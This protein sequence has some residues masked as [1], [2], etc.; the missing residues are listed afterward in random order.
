ML[1]SR[2]YKFF[3]VPSAHP[4]NFRTLFWFTHS[5]TLAAIYA[6]LALGEAFSSEYVVQDDARQHVFWMMRFIDP[7]LFP[8]D[9]IADYFQSVAPPGY[10]TL[11]QVAASLGIPPL[12]FNKILPFLLGLLTT[13]YTF[14]VSMQ[15]LPVPFAGFCSAAILNLSL[16]MRNDLVSG[17]P[18]AFIYPLFV[19]FIYYLLTHQK[20]GVW[21]V[22]ALTGLFYPQYVLVESGVLILLL[23][24]ALAIDR[25][26]Q[27]LNLFWGG[28]VMAGFI[29]FPYIMTG[30]PFDPLISVAE[31]RQYPEFWA[32]GRNSFFDVNF[33]SFWLLGERSGFIPKRTPGILWVGLALPFLYRYFSVFS[34][35]KKITRKITILIQVAFSSIFL[36]FAAHAVL[37]KLHLPSR[38][39]IHS[40]IVGLALVSGITIVVVL[41]AILRWSIEKTER[42]NS[43]KRR[44]GVWA[45]VLVVG[46]IVLYPISLEQF[47]RTSY[48]VGTNLDLYQ[49]F[50]EQPPDTLIA[51]L[52]PETDNF[53]SFSQRSVLVAE[54]YSIAY[55]MGYYQQFRQRLLDLVQAQYSSSL[56]PVSQLIKQYGV[57][58]LVINKSAFKPNYIVQNLWLNGLRTSRVANGDELAVTIQ[59]SLEFLQAGKIPAIAQTFGSCAIYQTS[60]VLVLEAQCISKIANPPKM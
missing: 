39:T 5:L 20:L 3:T 50:K 2:L 60:S 31:A 23:I 49:F 36:F 26:S 21:V 38:Y 16:W 52:E 32:G 58:F 46:A 37:F 22:I 1:I 8:N 27:S 45:T 43:P 42:K 18:R 29:L 17:T 47:P 51:S 4:H 53:P 55:H 56:A 15:F 41:E 6:S 25:K 59:N 54:E 14:G 24:W 33:W 19:A 9:L 11:Y 30:N 7:M 28:L 57:D 13:A 10:T 35:T 48:Q 34:L 44:F 40:A 12:I